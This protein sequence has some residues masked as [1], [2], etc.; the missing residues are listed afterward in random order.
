MKKKVERALRF[1]DRAHAGQRR[2]GGE[3]FI[4]HPVTVA[5][6]L[7]MYRYEDEDIFAAA[8]LHD[9]VED[10]DVTLADIQRAFGKRIAGIVGELTKKPDGTF[11]LKTREAHIIKLADRIHN[12]LD[13]P[14]RMRRNYLKKTEDLLAAHGENFRAYAPDLYK[15]LLHLMMRRTESIPEG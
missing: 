10:T 5:A 8:L 7:T 3:K 13:C 15:A 12:L 11:G 9:T 4:T 6:I 1:A 14:P 2:I